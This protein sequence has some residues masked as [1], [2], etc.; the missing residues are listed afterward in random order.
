[1]LV[2][3]KRILLILGSVLLVSCV[4]N[5]YKSCDQL[6]AIASKKEVASYLQEWAAKHVFNAE[7]PSAHVVMYGGRAPASYLYPIESHSIGFDWRVLGYNPERQLRISLVGPMAADS[8]GPT[9]TNVKSVFFSERSRY[10]ILVKAPGASDYGVGTH[11]KFLKPI[12]ENIA[13]IC[14]IA[15]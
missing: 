1:M 12:S 2:K 10:G 7:V 5:S 15:D 3:L 11:G 8:M 6:V 9:I 13:V 14:I 4:P